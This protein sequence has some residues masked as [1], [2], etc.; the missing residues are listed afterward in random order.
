MK[1]QESEKILQQE[2]AARIAR[3]KSEHTQITQEKAALE[4]EKTA[5]QKKLAQEKKEAQELDEQNKK[6]SQKLEKLK[7]QV[8]ELENQVQQAEAEFD[9]DEQV[10]VIDDSGELENAENSDN[11]IL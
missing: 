10:L 7:K 11:E 1:R 5:T 9:Q 2:S 3:E 4:K 8:A 6:E